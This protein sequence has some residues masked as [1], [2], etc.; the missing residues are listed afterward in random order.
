ML[1][2]YTLA[3]VLKGAGGGQKCLRLWINQS[4]IAQKNKN[5]TKKAADF[6]DP[7]PL[8]DLP[9]RT[10]CVAGS[11]FCFGIS[12]RIIVA[13]CITNLY[14]TAVAVADPYATE[15][16]YTM[17]LILVVFINMRPIS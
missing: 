14:D 9:V 1:R 13:V 2:D 17:R 7:P 11:L 15:R 5:I 10:L 4:T 6:L 8:L 16:A 3:V 12:F